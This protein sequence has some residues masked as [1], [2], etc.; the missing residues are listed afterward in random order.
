MRM[1]GAI[2]L[3]IVQYYNV[4]DMLQLGFLIYTA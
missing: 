2:T 3:A 1:E 4:L